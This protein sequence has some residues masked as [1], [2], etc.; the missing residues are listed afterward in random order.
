MK[1]NRSPLPPLTRGGFLTYFCVIAAAMLLAGCGDPPGTP[2]QQQGTLIVRGVLPG[3]ALADSVHIILDQ[4][5][6]GYHA[7][8]DTLINLWAG[9]HW[10][11]TKTVGYYQ[12]SLAEYLGIPGAVVI[13]NEQTTVTTCSLT[14][15]IPVAP[16]VNFKAPGFTCYDLDSNLVC[17]DS[18]QGRVVVLYF[19]SFG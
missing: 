5:T 4:D 2:V 1:W 11:E 12:D 19:W 9:T 3:G 14:A 6:L 15:E 10:L 13:D 16:Y 7:N 8:P 17:L 18:L